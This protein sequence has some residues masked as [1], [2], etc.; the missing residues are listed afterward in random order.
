MS[1]TQFFTDPPTDA[2][3]IAVIGAGLA[4][5]ACS[6]VLTQAGHRVALFDKA[7]GPGGRMSSKRRPEATVDLGA[8]AFTVRDDDFAAEV[9]R[10]RA[11]GCVAEW[12]N[13]LYQANPS[14]WQ[15]HHDGQ[16]RYTGAP[17]MSA[18]TRHLAETLTPQGATFYTSTRITALTNTAAGWELTCENGD[19]VGP[20]TQVVITAPPPQAESLVQPLDNT[21]FSLCKRLPQQSCWAGWVV[22]ETPLPALPG[23]ASDWQMARAQHPALR[24]IARNRTKPGREAEPESVSLI[25]Q[26]DWSKAH[27]EDENDAVAQQL[28]DALKS[29]FP[30]PLTFP[31]VT[32]IGAHRWRYSQPAEDADMPA[33]GFAIGRD[34]LALCGDS[35]RGGRVEDA[36]LSGYRLAQALLEEKGSSPR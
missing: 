17:R 23:V 29:V 20:Y 2:P 4:G 21:L 13:S 10:W 14:G 27:L 18:I 31:K 6:N 12:P 8:Q 11:A 35:L 36:W 1:A 5:L 22:F 7:R 16:T 28:F 34:G 32:D 15:T 24:L 3:A 30:A 25:A 19:V 26:L 33:E 9:E